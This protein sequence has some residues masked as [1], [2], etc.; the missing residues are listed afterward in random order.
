MET[1]VSN[2]VNY[3]LCIPSSVKDELIAIRHWLHIQIALEGE[4]FWLS[5]FTEKEISSVEVLQLSVKYYYYQKA[6]FL[7][8]IDSKVPERRLPEGLEWKALKEVLTLDTPKFN[9]NF[10]G[11]QTQVNIKLKPAE[12][13]RGLKAIKTTVEQL[14]P[15]LDTIPD[16]RLKDLEWTLFN[17]NQ[18]I[19]FT[20]TTLPIEGEAYWQLKRVFLPLGYEL[21]FNFLKDHIQPQ[22]DVYFFI[23]KSA[24]IIEI[25]RTQIKPLTRAG[26]RL[27][28]KY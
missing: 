15:I 13:I 25:N 27:T 17:G 4:W 11:L 12:Q 22:E 26:F 20:N 1:N 18:V 5:G 3:F 24:S 14:I 21:E 2:R 23:D 9:P 16:F 19:V 10:F 28:T 6:N 7:F 8:Y